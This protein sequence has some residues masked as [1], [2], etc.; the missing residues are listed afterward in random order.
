MIMRPND[1]EIKKTA[2]EQ[3]IHRSGFGMPLYLKHA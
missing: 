1:D 2:K 3:K